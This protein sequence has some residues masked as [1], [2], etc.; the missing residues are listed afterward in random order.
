VQDARLLARWHAAEYGQSLSPVSF[1]NRAVRQYGQH[2]LD[3]V[4]KPQT[5][6]TPYAER[7]G[8]LVEMP[9]FESQPKEHHD[10]P[11]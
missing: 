1:A 4:A 6:T 3:Q 9:A 2:L 8:V 11:H 7:W 10:R 5:L